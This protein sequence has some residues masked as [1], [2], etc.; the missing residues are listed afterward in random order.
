MNNK[1]IFLLPIMQLAAG[2]GW[3]G[4]T[5]AQ[6][7][8]SLWLQILLQLAHY[9]PIALLLLCAISFLT[10]QDTR[11]SWGRSGLFALSIF[12]KIA[13]IAWI[14]V[15]FTHFAGLTG[16]HGFND[17]FPIGVTNAGSGLL[18]GLLIAHRDQ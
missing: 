2:L 1:R 4:G 11:H 14:I 7:S 8:W 12:V 3:I 5:Y 18:L 16:P 17:W 10:I 15:G 9:L 13:T 6:S